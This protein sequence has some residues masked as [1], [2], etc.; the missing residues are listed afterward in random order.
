MTSIR[1]LLLLLLI[2]A[3]AGSPD[4]APAF[5]TR[6][7]AGITIAENVMADVTSRCTVDSV[8]VVRIGGDQDSD[9][10][11]L[12]R[13][14]GTSRLSD[15][16]IAVVN[17]G[18]QEV[19]WYDST[20][21]LVGR[22]GRAGRGPGEFTDAFLMVRM[23]GDTLW[24]GD[25]RPWQWH[26]FGPDMTFVR[27]VVTTPSEINSPD[28]YAVFDDGQ[29][30]FGTSRIG[31]RV[32]WAMDS[33]TIKRFTPDG[34]LRDTVV[35]VPTGRLGQTAGEGSVWMRP[36]FEGAAQAEGSGD[37]LAVATWG[38]PELV[39]YHV[40]DQ[41]TPSLI[42]RWTTADRTVTDSAVT[43]AR[44]KLANQYPDL[45]AEM[46]AQMVDPLIS[47][48]RPVAERY[49]AV[50]RIVM[51]TDGRI[52]VRGYAPSEATTR[53][54]IAFSREGRAVCRAELPEVDYLYEIGRD[55][56]LT[57]ERDSL[58]VERVVEYRLRGV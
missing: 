36:W 20:G 42:I 2:V 27:S 26:I 47:A 52:W 18:T 16:R 49:P 3:C 58:G 15:G 55:Y 4:A 33:V 8:P 50:T 23:P 39:I 9:D 11:F 38:E 29:Q 5:V 35:S 56:L 34:I 24:V 51:G 1:A 12:Y 48:K 46:K 40:G 31:Q 41:V 13:V 17:Q 21:V 6:D 57:H 43:A 7:S 10:D 44:E 54:W 25:Y 14:M 19:R 53:E 22:A 32:S 28:I 30:V 37:R 45:S